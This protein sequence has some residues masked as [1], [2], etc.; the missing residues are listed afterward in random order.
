MKRAPGVRSQKTKNPGAP[1]S[2][3][4]RK[5]RRRNEANERAELRAQRSAKA[6]LALADK[7]PGE[8]KRERARLRGTP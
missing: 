5:T 3:S 1:W 2:Q 7:R 4:S 8:S 6:Q